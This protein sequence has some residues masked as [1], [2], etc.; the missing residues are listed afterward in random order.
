MTKPTTY[1]KLVRDR[2]PDIISDHGERPEFVVL[3]AVGFQK[4]LR[5][6]LVEGARE[7]SVARAEREVENELVDLYEI[8][9]AFE[10]VYGLRHSDLIDWQEKKRQERGGFDKRIYLVRTVPRTE[11]KA[12]K[13]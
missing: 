9:R 13:S 8:L 7:L 3:D 10:K 5:Q 2:I 12:K 4:A 11:T 6:K 1:N